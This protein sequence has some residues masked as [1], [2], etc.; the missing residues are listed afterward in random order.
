MQT[1]LNEKSQ[2]ILSGTRQSAFFCISYWFYPPCTLYEAPSPYGKPCQIYGWMG[3]DLFLCLSAF[4]FA[5]LLFVEYQEKGNI[6][7]GYFYLRRALRIWPLYF[8]FVGVMLILTIQENGWNTAITQRLIGML[9]FTDNL[10]CSKDRLQR[11]NPVL[12]PYLDYFIRR[13]ILSDHPLGIAQVLPT[14]TLD[15]CHHPYHR[16]TDRLVN[17]GHYYLCRCPTSG[18]LGATH[19]A[20]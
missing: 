9:T 8:I 20:L 1:S 7:I 16:Y 18:H 3:V 11:C 15:H 14:Q 13:A 2:S 10:V 4:L 5:R 19:N 17:Q 12:R 6:N